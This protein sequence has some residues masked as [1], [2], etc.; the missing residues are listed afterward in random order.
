M[1]IYIYH[2]T[3]LSLSLSSL[4]H[5]L[6]GDPEGSRSVFGQAFRQLHFV[7]PDNLRIPGQTW[8]VT[9]EG[10]GGTDAGG[11]FRD[12]ISHICSDLQS[13]Y[14]P[15]FIPCP[16]AKGNNFISKKRTDNNLI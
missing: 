3:A 2:N 5:I 12:S 13:P 9:Y 14:V 6:A 15:L 10:E 16:N 11:L 1:F 7:K 4:T 8:R